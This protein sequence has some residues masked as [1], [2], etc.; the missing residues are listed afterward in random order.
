MLWVDKY[1]PQSLNR[2]DYHQDLSRRLINLA[3]SD[4]VPHLLFYGPSGAG[5]KT[6]VMSFLRELFGSGVEKLKLEHRTFKTPS[7]KTIE[8]SMISSNFHI[9]MNACDAGIYDRI[10]IQDI[11]KEMAQSHPIQSVSSQHS[12]KVIFLVEV[13]RLTRQAQAALRR[14]MEKY[15]SSCRIIMCCNSLSKVIEPVR[16]RCLTIRIAA[17]SHEEI[18]SV[19]K[20]IAK[21]EKVE[22]PNELAMRIAHSSQ[23]NMRRAILMMEACRVQQYPFVPNQTVPLSDWETFIAQLGM[24]IVQEQSP[25]KLLEAR[26]KLYELLINCIPA[27][28]ILRTLS[29]ELMK[30][31]DDQL[32]HEVAYW[33]A[34][35]EQ[36]LRAGSKEIFHLEAFVAKFMSLYKGFLVNLFG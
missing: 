20:T 26:E 16:S 24:S 34:F 18:C 11:I 12:F 28:V 7:G 32:K 9:E 29:R 14:T 23:R 21:K 4:Q 10:I 5:K 8:I 31:L 19:L 6:R 33:A 30:Q 25:Q 3:Q 36:R 27:D 1:R 15:T 35:Y 17:P 22:L 13:D 2:L